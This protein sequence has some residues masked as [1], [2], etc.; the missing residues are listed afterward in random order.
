MSFMKKISDL[1]KG[2][3][4][5]VDANLGGGVSPVSLEELMN[6]EIV[7]YLLSTYKKQ[8]TLLK[9]HLSDKQIDFT[10]SKMGGVPNLNG[11][12][13][14][15]ICDEC[16]APLNFVL[17]LYKKDFPDFYFPEDKTIFQIFRCPNH[18]E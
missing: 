15:P 5:K 8:T 12:K 14:W 17:Q 3:Q 7:S 4:I 16:D 10:K 6:D 11:F 13:E 2:K 9:P 18:D 1:F